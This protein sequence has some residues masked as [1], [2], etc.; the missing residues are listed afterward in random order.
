M[1]LLLISYSKA[2]R[3]ISVLKEQ[4]KAAASQIKARAGSAAGSCKGRAGKAMDGTNKGAKDPKEPAKKVSKVLMDR[5]KTSPG[6]LLSFPS[7]VERSVC[8]CFTLYE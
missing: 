1:S 4:A 2:K 6:T 5:H 7:R 3:S 8:F